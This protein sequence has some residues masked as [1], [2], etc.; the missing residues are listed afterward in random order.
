MTAQTAAI[1]DDGAPQRLNDAR[2]KLLDLAADLKPFT[3]PLPTLTE[4]RDRVDA[5]LDEL[6]EVRRSFLLVVH[7]YECERDGI[8]E[9]ATELQKRVDDG[10][11]PETV[12]LADVLERLTPVAER[13]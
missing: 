5:L 3:A 9:W 13:E 12:P 2:L 8:E 10:W 7:T 11:R 6:N 4:L 1:A